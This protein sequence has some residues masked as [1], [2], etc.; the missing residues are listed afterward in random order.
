VKITLAREIFTHP[1]ICWEM[2]MVFPLKTSQF[3]AFFWLAPALL[4]T[5][6]KSV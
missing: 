1:L 2:G 4:K 3:E 5:T 6:Q